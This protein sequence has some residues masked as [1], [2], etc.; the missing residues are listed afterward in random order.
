MQPAGSS[1]CTAVEIETGHGRQGSQIV[2]SGQ[3]SGA[4]FGAWCR[5]AWS[6]TIS[7]TKTTAGPGTAQRQTPDHHKLSPGDFGVGGCANEAKSPLTIGLGK[8]IS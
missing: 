5:S 8:G 1:R 3:G 4:V 7:G 6:R 2:E